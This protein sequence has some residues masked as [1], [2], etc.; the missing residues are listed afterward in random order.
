LLLNLTSRELAN[1][2][3]ATLHAFQCQVDALAEKQNGRSTF[4]RKGDWKDA[5]EAW[6]HERMRPSV[7]QNGQINMKTYP[8]LAEAVQSPFHLFRNSVIIF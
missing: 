7:K 5:H 2:V 4:N 6:L 1:N 3:F 8:F